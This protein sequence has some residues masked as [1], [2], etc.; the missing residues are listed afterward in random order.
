LISH[1]SIK[2]FAIIENI[3]VDFH[4]GLNVMTGETGSGKSIIIEA[5]SLALGS[6]ADTAFVRSGKEK[7]LIQ[8]VL[9]D[10]DHNET[11]L[12]RE[13]FVSGKSSC[14]INDELVTL[15]RLNHFCK[16]IADIHGQYDHQSLLN[17]DNHINLVDSFDSTAILPLKDV[18]NETFKRYSSIKKELHT[19]LKE[20]ES[21]ARKKDFMH[22]ELQEIDAANLKE[23]EDIILSAALPILQNSERIAENL[24][25]VYE[26]L[27]SGSDSGVTDLGKAMHLLKDLAPLSPDL[28]L[29]YTTIS[30]LYYKLED[31]STDIRKFKETILFSPEEIDKTIQRLDLIDSLKRKYGGSISRILAYRLD[32]IHQIERIDYSDELQQK[33]RQD[34]TICEQKLTEQSQE[35]SIL[36]KKIALVIEQRIRLELDDLN[37]PDS[38]LLI[39][40]NMKRTEYGSPFFTENGYDSIEF[41]IATNKGEPPKPLSKIA[42]GGEISRI[43]LAFKRIIGEYDNIPTMI[44]DEIDSGISGATASIVGKKLAS[45][46]KN[47]QIICITHLPQIAAVSDHHYKIL[48][49]DDGQQTFTIIQPL[50]QQGKILEV[51]RLLS[52][53]KITEHTIKNAE[54][55][56]R[57]AHSN[58]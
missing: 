49:R 20:Q 55:L 31:T 22:Y 23:D 27:Y 1:I 41:L 51:A 35:L 4:K 30:D 33:L 47:H 8:L 37:F 44:F 40:I 58:D 54:E 24:S 12:T 56:I 46:S 53:L 34:L 28:E 43:M 32:L 16:S 15:S 39:Q 42:S 18:L 57:F 3:S 45:I 50:D 17:P 7:A 52:G 13:I 14:K 9:E 36:R 29:Y 21:A 2:D 5:V 6:R 48:K 19:L 11:I 26:L 38:I 10:E 25:L